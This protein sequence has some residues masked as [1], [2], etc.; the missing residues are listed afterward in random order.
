[1]YEDQP[2]IHQTTD[3]S[4]AEKEKWKNDLAKFCTNFQNRWCHKT[5]KYKHWKEAGCE[6]EPSQWIAYQQL[7]YRR[8]MHEPILVNIP[9]CRLN[10]A[11]VLS[12]PWSVPYCPVPTKACL[13]EL[14]LNKTNVDL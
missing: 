12:H 5:K 7:L 11:L 4:L 9:Y 2:R 6:K 13:P 14:L 8:Y 3:P 10:F 1:M